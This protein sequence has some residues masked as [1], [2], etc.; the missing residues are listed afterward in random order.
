MKVPI[1]SVEGKKIKDIEL[2][3]FFSWQIREDIIKKIERVKKLRE[4]QPYSNSVLAGNKASASGKI[5]HRRNKWK[6][7]YGHGI[8]RVPRKIFWRRGDRFYWQGATISGTRGG[9]RAHPPKLKAEKKKINKKEKLFALKIAL[10]ATSNQE[11][12]KKRYQTLNKKTIPKLPII[13]ESRIL[14][15]KTKEFFSSLKKILNELYNVA[16][17]KRKIRAGKGKLRGRKYKKSKGMLLVLGNNEKYKI[18]GIEIKQADKLGVKDLALGEP[19]R[20]VVYTENSI[21]T[22]ENLGKKSTG[23]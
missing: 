18:Q 10:A 8:S 12:L 17:Q 6:T 11:L 21:K 20:L 1:L 9:R 4:K 22:L 16:L 5:K 23:K 13:V 14:Q 15:F 7:S 2:P 19:G 3:E